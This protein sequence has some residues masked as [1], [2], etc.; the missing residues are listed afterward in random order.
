VLNVLGFVPGVIVIVSAASRRG[1][2]SWL[3]SQIVVAIIITWSDYVVGTFKLNHPEVYT[4]ADVGFLIGGP[5]GRE[6]L[7]FAYWVGNQSA[8]CA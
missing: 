8:P 7:G 6:I 3:I 1:V 4:L 5:I 2:A